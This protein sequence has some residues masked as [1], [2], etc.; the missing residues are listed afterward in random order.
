MS[1]SVFVVYRKNDIRGKNICPFV[2]GARCKEG[3]IKGCSG[4]AKI[5]MPLSSVDRN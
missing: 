3:S 5:I 1:K 2:G 4:A